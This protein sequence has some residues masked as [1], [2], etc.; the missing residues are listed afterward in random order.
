MELLQPRLL[1]K[2]MSVS[3]FEKS[4]P[5]RCNPVGPMVSISPNPGLGHGQA[6]HR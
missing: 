1:Q 2:Y 5:T 3:P 4:H 6:L